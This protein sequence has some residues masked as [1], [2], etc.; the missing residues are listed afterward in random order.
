MKETNTTWVSSVR[1]TPGLWAGRRALCF[2]LLPLLLTV[3]CGISPLYGADTQRAPVDVNLIMDGSAGFSDVKEDITAWVSKRLDSIL[4]D[5][6]R[7]TIWNAGTSAKV[8]YSGRINGN[9]DREA[10]RKI[11]RE[12]SVS[13]NSPDFSGALKEASGRQSLSFSYTLLI[14]ASP[15][16]LSPLLS[17]P[18]ANLLRFSRVEEFSGWR[19]LVVGLDLDPKVRKAA[20]GFFG[21]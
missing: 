13:G 14:S 8:I 11:I 6:D 12:F 16:A 20:A 18:Q 5:G 7:V 19:A 4:A 3:F 21:S 9:S 10:V 2:Q 17:G 1:K 15:A